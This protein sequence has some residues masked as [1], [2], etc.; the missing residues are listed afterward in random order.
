MVL[1]PLH[2]P[3]TPPL[4]LQTDLKYLIN[5]KWHYGWDFGSSSGANYLYYYICIGI[6]QL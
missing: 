5:S 1:W 3:M 4:N 6:L 2:W